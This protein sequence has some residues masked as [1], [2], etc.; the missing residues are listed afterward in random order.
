MVLDKLRPYLKDFFENV[1]KVFATL[2]LT[3]NFLS[4][5]SLILA[6][7]AGISFYYSRSDIDL[8]L[9]AVS[10]VILSGFL[11]AVDGALAR[12]TGKAGPKGDFL[13]HVIDRYADVFL[14]CGVFFGGYGSW[15]VGVVAITGILICSYLGTQAQAVNIGRYYGGIMG[16]A[17]RLVLL[18][19]FTMMNYAAPQEIYGMQLLGWL[20]V[21]FAIT[22][23]ISAIQRFAHIWKELSS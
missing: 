21:V 6:F 19:L 12:Y 20:I 13:D 8:L 14:I 3:P 15:E 4:V 9:V 11:D 7:V 18:V 22:S 5:I 1:A 16:R 17:D 10:L 23:H 2:G